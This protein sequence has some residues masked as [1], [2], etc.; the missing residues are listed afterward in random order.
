MKVTHILCAVLAAAS[1]TFGLRAIALSDGGV[2]TEAAQSG[3]RPT[4]PK[5][6][7][8]TKAGRDTAVGVPARHGAAIPRHPAG[9]ATRGNADRMHLLTNAQASERRAR[10]PSRSVG[11]N[12]PVKPKLALSNAPVRP[13]GN[14]R[15]GGAAIGRPAPRALID[16]TQPHRKF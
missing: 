7:A 9:Q 3:A 11:V 12:P 5:R 13:Q 6:H 8:N 1:L 16:G 10:Q 15:L 2:A 4:A 14:G